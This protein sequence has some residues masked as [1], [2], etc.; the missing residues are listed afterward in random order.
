MNE[1]DKR[2]LERYEACLKEIIRPG[3]YT[4]QDYPLSGC[5]HVACRK[6]H[7]TYLM[8]ENA[9]YP[10]KLIELTGEPK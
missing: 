7:Q 3:Y 2:K 9:L 6:N 8:V 1:E 4:C 5:A 10:P